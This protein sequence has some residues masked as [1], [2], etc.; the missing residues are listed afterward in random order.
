MSP[1]T[2][3]YALGWEGRSRMAELPLVK[4]HCFRE[5]FFNHDT[6]II[7]IERRGSSMRS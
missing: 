1:D 2:M 5:T 6:A 4:N 3:K 7:I